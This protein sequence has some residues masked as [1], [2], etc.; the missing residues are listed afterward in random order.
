MHP[1]NSTSP[2]RE[3]L[4]RR[5]KEAEETIR[6]IREGEIDALVMRAALNEQVFT[7]HGG[8]DSYR[9]FMETMVHGAAALGSKGEILYVNSILSA[10]IG[11]PLAQLQGQALADQFDAAIGAQIQTLFSDAELSKF[12][13]ELV[14]DH[15]R[16]T[17]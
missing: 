6:A 14:R 9:A 12:C 11:K 1:E 15:A 2:L 17:R 16:S 5:L 13:G 3:E 10:M 7:L 4:L 8:D